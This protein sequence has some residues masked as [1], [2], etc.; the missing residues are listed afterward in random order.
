MY[1][2]NRQKR[3]RKKKFTAGVKFINTLPAGRFTWKT[4]L[5][6]SKM[7]RLDKII[8]CFFYK[9]VDLNAPHGVSQL[10]SYGEIRR[11]LQKVV[12][13]TCTGE[14]GAGFA[15]KKISLQSEMKRNEIRLDSFSSV[16]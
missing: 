2:V 9:A 15:L 8:C 11:P 10:R 6:T 4:A 13:A 5:K 12:L 7:L 16:H 14:G 3:S 1:V